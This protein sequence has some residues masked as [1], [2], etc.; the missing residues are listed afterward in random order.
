MLEWLSSHRPTCLPAGEGVMPML[1]NPVQ[2]FTTGFGDWRRVLPGGEVRDFYV[3]LYPNGVRWETLPTPMLE[4]CRAWVE[5]DFARADGDHLT[6]MIPIL[7]QSDR[8]LL[9]PWFEALAACTTAAVGDELP[10]FRGLAERFNDRWNT[11][12]HILTIL[13]L[14]A[15]N[16]WVLRR[17]LAGPI[18]R[19][20]EHGDTGRYFIWAEELGPGPTHIT[21]IRAIRG[22]VGYGLCVI[23]SRIVDRPGLKHA[24]RLYAQVGG[25]SAVDLLAKL[26]AEQ[27]S[28]PALTRRW[29]L[30]PETLHRWLDEQRSVRV[31]TPDEPA[32]VR[33]PVLG[34]QAMAQIA[35]V[36]GGVARRITAWLHEDAVLEPLLEHCSFARCPRPA[37]LCMLW[38]NSYYEATDRLIAQGVLPPFPAVAEAEWG[39]WLTSD[40]YG[41]NPL[42]NVR[43]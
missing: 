18:G 37:I 6:P 14:W 25:V 23:I 5:C 41:P 8:D 39:V 15:I 21:G 33:I 13:I 29:G 43:P 40:P 22:T 17:L 20:P 26:I 24:R 34:P 9:H 28:L 42:R 11:A 36:C 31:V 4:A 38:H 12:E 16:M 27:P 19:H 30:E 32:Q 3:Q 7:T 1:T 2:F 10:T 35:P